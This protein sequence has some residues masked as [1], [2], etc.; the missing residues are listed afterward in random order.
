MGRAEAALRLS[1]IMSCLALVVAA[2][3]AAAAAASMTVAGSA[4]GQ[5]RDRHTLLHR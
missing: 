2:A 5:V 3:A 1:L 4:G